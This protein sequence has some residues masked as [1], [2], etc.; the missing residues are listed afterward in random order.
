VGLL[1]G[2][3]LA[4]ETLTLRVLD[5]EHYRASLSFDPA[6]GTRIRDGLDALL[7][8]SEEAFPVTTLG[9]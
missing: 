8:R 1:K 4:P 2:L 5:P 6:D 3:F 7:Q 9:L